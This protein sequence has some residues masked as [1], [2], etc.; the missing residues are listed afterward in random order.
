[1]KKMMLEEFCSDEE[2]QRIKDEL[3]SLKLRDTNITAYTQRFH[4]L[5]LLCPEA[6][7]IEK[8]KEVEAY[9]KG[10]PENIKGEMTSSRPVNMNEFF[11]MAHTLMEQKIQAKAE[12]I[13]EGNK[14]KWENLQGGNRNNNPRGNYQGNTR[15]Q[16]YNNQR[17][18]CYNCRRPGHLAKDC[19]RKLTPV[20]YGYGERGHTRNYC[21]KKKNPQGEDA[22]GRAYVIKEADKDQGPNVVMVHVPYKN[23]TLVVEGDRGAS[24]LKVISCIKARKFIKRGSQLFVAHMTEKEP[25]EKWIED[26]PVIRHFLEVFPDDLPGLLPPRQVEFRIDLVP[27]AAPVKWIEDVPV[28]RHFL[29]VFPDDLPGLLP[30]RQVEFRID[31]VLGAAPVV[32]APYRTF[33]C[34]ALADLGASINLMPYSLYAKLSIETLKPTKISVRLTDRSFQYPV[35]IAENMLVEIE[36]IFAEFDE[37]MAMTADENSDSKSDTVKPTFKKITINTNYKI[38]TSLEEPPMD[39]E[40]KPLP[41]NLEYV[42]L[43]EPSFLL[44]IISS[45][46]SKEKKNKLVSILKKHKQ[47]FAW[48]TTNILGIYPD[49]RLVINWEKCHFMV[50]EGIVLGHKVSSTGFEVDKAK[51]DII[52]KL[53]PPANIKADHLSRIENDESSDDNKVD[54]NFPEETL[55]EIN[56]KDKPWFADFANYL[57][58]D[59]IPK[60]MTY[61]QKYKFFSDL[62]HYFWE[63]PY[64]FK[65]CSDG[66]IRRYVSGL[67]T[68]TILDQCHHGPTGGHYRPNVTAK[69]VLDSGFYWPTII[70]EAL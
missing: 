33:S 45:Q 36:E 53:P 24:R 19:R 5:V 21:P 2:V 1:M 42:F 56:T 10:F 63:E 39:L 17:A 66:M 16:Q 44:V 28:I 41:D 64:L 57:V 8:K 69:R 70:K 7:P 62:K 9:I 68:Q 49:A 18:T 14:R 23:K 6:V 43:E 48:K 29:E 26:V 20:C 65:V 11:R 32:R 22:R 55:M 46:L 47:A 52:S 34:N 58:G 4:E 51:V 54:D 67:E 30:P 3:R 50:K 61:Q 38:K 60:G 37:F 59:V 35:G 31:L 40:L 27:G 12:R 15:H 25:Q 13:S